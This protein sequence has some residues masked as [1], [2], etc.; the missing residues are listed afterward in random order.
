MD[1]IKQNTYSANDIVTLSP[2]R[3]FREKIGYPD[4]LIYNDGKIYS[5]K[6]NKFLTPFK[7]STGYYAVNLYNFNGEPK[8]FFVHRLVAEAF[9]ENPNNYNNINHKDE[10]KSNN[11][12]SNLEW[13][14]H[15]YNENYGTK[16]QREMQTK[17]ETKKIN[18]RKKNGQFDLNN[19][20]IR[21]WDSL[22]EA[23]KQLNISI[24]NI[25]SVIHNKRNQA[26][27]FIWK[28]I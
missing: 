6:T 19:N 21:E 5:K 25:S 24:G 8:M 28:V 2:G 1:N 26:G 20:F 3:A 17:T 15:S 18:G 7:K 16:K 10:D 9:L 11:S 4:Y 12:L 27:G 23:S 13:C 22:T 14:D